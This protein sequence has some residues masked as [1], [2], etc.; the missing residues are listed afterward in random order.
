M[1]RMSIITMLAPPTLSSR[2][3]IPRCTQMA[4]VHDMAE[5]LVGDITPIDGMLK[6]EK[7]RRE[8]ATIDYICQD[9]LGDVDGGVQGRELKEVWYEYEDGETLESRFV[10]DVDKIELVLQMLE[11]ER[12]HAGKI[13]LGEFSWVAQRIMLPE[14]KQWCAEVLGERAGLWKELGKVPTGSDLSQERQ[15]Q[16]NEYYGN[17][18]IDKEQ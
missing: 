11:Y 5:T 15:A 9:L 10:H 4:L 8:A 17:G 7:S 13:D 12:S 14:V 3:N 6:S 2:L 18:E 16:Q 1:Y